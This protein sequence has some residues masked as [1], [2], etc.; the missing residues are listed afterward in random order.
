MTLAV[1][2]SPEV[3]QAL[4]PQVA[5]QARGITEGRCI[6]CSRPLAGT[7]NV[8]LGQS[9][10]MDAG[11]VWFVHADCAPSRIVPLNAE[12]TAAIVQ[13]ADGY[14]MTIAAAMVDGAPALV[15]RLVMTPVTTSGTPGSEPRS[16]FMESLFSDGFSLIT[17][18]GMDAPVLPEWIAVFKPHGRDLQLVILTPEGSIYFQGILAKPMP[19]WVKAVLAQRQVLLLAG[20]IPGRHDDEPEQVRE[21]LAAAARNGQLAGARVAAGRPSDFGLAE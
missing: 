9:Q 1:L 12:A 4:G 2:M 18:A 21:A 13:P 7:V 3:E 8:V 20:D 5:I 19:G 17:P 11:S 15:S 10:T 16:I 14:S 6:E